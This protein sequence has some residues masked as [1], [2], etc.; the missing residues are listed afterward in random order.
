MW[1]GRVQA[2]VILSLLQMHSLH[3][4][5]F[6][7]KL[8][9]YIVIISIKCSLQSR[10]N[11]LIFFQDLQLYKSK[12]SKRLYLLSFFAIDPS[13]SL[14]FMCVSTEMRS[15][16]IS[17]YCNFLCVHHLLINI[18]LLVR[19]IVVVSIISLVFCES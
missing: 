4:P 16:S 10:N 18:V 14:T 11:V 13:I 6:I 12:K 8:W 9:C 3:I 5:L 19:G 7:V 15:I 2:L 17:L 1:T